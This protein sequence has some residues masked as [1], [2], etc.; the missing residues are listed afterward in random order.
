MLVSTGDVTNILTNSAEVSGLVIDLGEGATQHGHCYGTTPNVT[1][2]ITK[3]VLGQPPAGSFTSQLEN[4]E[5]GTKYYVKAYLSNGN[6]TVYGKEIS[7]TTPQPP[8]S[9]EYISSVV[10]N[11]TPAVLEMT[12]CLELANVVPAASAFTVMVNSVARTV[13]SVVIS[14]TKVQLTIASAVVYGDIV[15][16]AYTKPG[17]NALQTPSGGQAESIAPQ[18][19]T[20]NCIAVPT[21][22]TATV[23]SITSTTAISGGDITINGGAAVTAS[24]V[25]W[26]TSTNP[27]AT[28]SHTTD[29]T[30]TG[31]FTSSITGLIASTTYYVRAYATNSAGT[32]YGNEETFATLASGGTVT[33]YEGNVY[34]TITIGTQTWM[35]ENLKSTTYND[36]TPIPFVTDG[37]AWGALSTP[38]YCWNNNDEASYKNLYGALYNWHSVNTGKLCPTGWHIP[39]DTE[40]TTLTTFLG[41]VSAGGKLKETGTTH[42]SSPNTGATNESGF[43]ALPGG[44]RSGISGAFTDVGN[45]CYLSSATENDALNANG[46]SMDF[47]TSNVANLLGSKKNGW[48]VRCIEGQAA[49]LPVVLT[50]NPYNI[51][52]NSATVGGNVTADGGDAVTDRGVYL[53]TSANAETTGTKLQ[54]GSGTGQFSLNLTGLTAGTTYYIRAY[55]TNNAGTA[56]GNEISFATSPVVATVP[57]ISTATP[58]SITTDAATSG[59]NITSDGGATVIVSGVCWSTSS[60]PVA[61]GNHTTDGSTSGT[62]T[63][64]ITGLSASTTYYVRA[65]ATNS[66]GTAYGEEYIIKTASGT[67]TD[68]D[69]NVYYTMTIGTQVWMAENLKT[70]TYNDGTSIPNV[71]DGAT[72]AAL[73]TGAYSDYDNTPSNSSTYG[74]LYNWYAV[75]NNAATKVASNGGKNVCPTGWHVPSDDEWT[76]LENYLITNG[77]NYDGTTTDNKIAKSLASIAGWTSSTTIGAVGN[78][79]YPNKRNATGFTA[80]PGGYRSGGGPYWSVNYRGLL[81]SSSEISATG[82]LY[83]DMNYNGVNVAKGIYG[84]EQDGFSVRCILD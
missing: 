60:N 73:T 78:T 28:G 63:S 33:D 45:D 30:T 1:I 19:V 21:I 72:W 25:C 51:T 67:V 9:P 14:G 75:D 83:R 64:S 56:Y 49:S 24:G 62:F 13:S 66:A 15:T 10:E 55:A 41:G 69:G 79:D 76:T 44:H 27:I 82:A 8:I 52:Q 3:T 16:V 53:S 29:G 43:T 4:L 74:R 50:T 5:A 61:S 42:W 80:L 65:Y 54:K 36:G 68:S 38:A 18:S 84:E 35:A 46:R 2:S 77:Y 12:Y 6:E 71:T 37:T 48:S 47:N 22:I 31:T 81:W 17:S 58:S 40:W 11:A 34:Q 70:T 7:F 23:T 39:T 20:N 26:G 32:A 57:T 59:G